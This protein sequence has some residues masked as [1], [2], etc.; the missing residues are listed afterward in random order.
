MLTYPAMV[1]DYIL[2]VRRICLADA[3]LLGM[4]ESI[5]RFTFY[6]CSFSNC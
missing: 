3:Y 1:S 6:K 4:R 5:G 2:A